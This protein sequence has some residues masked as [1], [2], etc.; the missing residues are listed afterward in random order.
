MGRFYV[1]MTNDKNTSTKCVMVL[2]PIE[3][4]FDDYEKMFESISNATEFKFQIKRK[5]VNF[6]G[7]LYNMWMAPFVD[8][9]LM[10]INT[11]KDEIPKDR[12]DFDGNVLRVYATVLDNTKEEL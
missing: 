10:L 7:G 3:S 11:E 12:L 1:C 5:Y 2:V 6:L 9:P 8:S 4:R